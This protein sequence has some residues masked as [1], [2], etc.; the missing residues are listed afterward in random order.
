MTHGD[1]KAPAFQLYVKEFLSDANQAGMSLQESG[2]YIRLMCFE[3]NEH[4]KGLP[5][6]FTRCA[7]MIGATPPQMRTMWKALRGCFVDHPNAPGRMLHPRLEKERQK[8]ETFKRRRSYA[9][10]KGAEVRWQTDGKDDGK[11]DGKAIA[12]PMA[13]DSSPV[14]SLPIASKKQKLSDGTSNHPIF[15]GQRLVVFDWF[16]EKAS[17]LLGNYLDDFDLHA[18]FMAVDKHAVNVRLVIPSRDGGAWLETQLLDE[19]KRRGLRI[20]GNEGDPYEKLTTAWMCA[21]C[22]EVHEGTKDQAQR[23]PCLRKAS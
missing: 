13:K 22:G 15:K 9:G 21:V 20:A 3:W 17:R 8:Q 10:K 1:G 5:D 11:H 7:R 12:T 2:A 23:R 16:I 6:D 18:W 14:S 19:A 4:G